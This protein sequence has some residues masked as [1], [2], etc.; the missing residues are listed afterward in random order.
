MAPEP[1][2]GSKLTPGTL[3]HDYVRGHFQEPSARLK[4]QVLRI[5]QLDEA[6]A[7][8]TFSHPFDIALHPRFYR[9]M[10][11]YQMALP[12]VKEGKHCSCAKHKVETHM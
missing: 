10:D 12:E 5:V 3:L 6:S 4:W 11:H 8:T 2:L 7:R 9:M 1:M